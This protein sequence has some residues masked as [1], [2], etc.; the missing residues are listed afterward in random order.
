MLFQALLKLLL[1][2]SLA[3][4]FLLTARRC[5]SPR[6]SRA[7]LLTTLLAFVAGLQVDPFALGHLRV[8]NS[9]LLR[10]ACLY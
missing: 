1:A 4:P 10:A 9:V 7:W 3:L 8:D 5:A 2:A 6:R